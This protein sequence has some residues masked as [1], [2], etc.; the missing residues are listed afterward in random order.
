MVTISLQKNFTRAEW[1][2]DAAVAAAATARSPDTTTGRWPSCPT[3]SSCTLSSD[4]AMSD[5]MPPVYAAAV[6]AVAGVLVAACQRRWRC[7]ATRE[8]VNPSACRAACGDSGKA[9]APD[10]VTSDCRR[11]TTPRRPSAECRCRRGGGGRAPVA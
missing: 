9:P 1:R 8:A 2:D 6:A 11:G 5:S 7:P 10:A 4:K 3:T